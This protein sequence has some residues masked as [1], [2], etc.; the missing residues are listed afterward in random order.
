MSRGS[1]R[2]HTVQDFDWY[3]NTSE[4]NHLINTRNDNSLERLRFEVGLRNYPL[5]TN[6]VAQEPWNVNPSDS[7]LKEIV[8]I[9]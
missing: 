9:T 4:I 1:K 2:A 8:P 7:P 6:F 5:K 3:G